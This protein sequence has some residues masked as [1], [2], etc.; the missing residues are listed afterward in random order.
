M[1]EIDT[2]TSF[3]YVLM[4]VDKYP[5]IPRG[6]EG[7]MPCFSTRIPVPIGRESV[8]ANLNGTFKGEQSGRGSD[9]SDSLEMLL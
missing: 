1:R 2:L 8:V 5:L 7:R 4:R 6:V 9:L 3:E